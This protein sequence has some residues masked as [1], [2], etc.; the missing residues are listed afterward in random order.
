MFQIA[1]VLNR[2][3]VKRFYERN[4]G[5]FLF[6]FLV[7]FGVVEGSQIISYHL[8]L[9][10]GMLGSGVFMAVVFGV[11]L[12][13]SVKCIQFVH[14]VLDHPKNG[15]LFLL[16]GLNKRKQFQYFLWVIFLL[17]LPVTVYS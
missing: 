16:R 7:M 2:V 1:G 8:S 15:F 9:I 4:T 11:W 10:A 14:E 12:A 17:F 6:V 5:F 3:I 13:Y